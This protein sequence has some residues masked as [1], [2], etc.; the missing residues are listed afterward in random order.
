LTGIAW[1]RLAWIGL[2]PDVRLAVHRLAL[3]R[4]GA[5]PLIEILLRRI[6]G[7]IRSDHRRRRS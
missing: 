2:L 1:L 5:I 6:T 4:T 7:A 3:G